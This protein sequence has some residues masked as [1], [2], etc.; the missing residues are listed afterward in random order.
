[1]WQLPE[2][3]LSKL[4]EALGICYKVLEVF[5]LNM[6]ILLSLQISFVDPVVSKPIKYELRGGITSFEIDTG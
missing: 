6:G 2:P 4:L 5:K 3:I 1:V